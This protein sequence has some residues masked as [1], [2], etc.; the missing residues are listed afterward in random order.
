[1]KRRIAAAVPVAMGNPGRED[2]ERA[3]AAVVQATFYLN[4]HCPLQNIE[5]LVHGVDVQPLW[6]AAICRRLDA[7]Y[8]AVFSTRR[9]TVQI[10]FHALMGATVFDGRE[11]NLANVFHFDPPRMNQ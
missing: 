4:T 5:N 11:I 8:G 7:V 9:V 2:N 3:W 6:G 1:M 10:Q